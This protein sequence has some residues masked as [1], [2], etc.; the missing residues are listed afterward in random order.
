MNNTTEVSVK[1]CTHCQKTLPI[2]HFT[3]NTSVSSGYGGHCKKC[4]NSKNRRHHHTRKNDSDY[5]A[6]SLLSAARNRTDDVSLTKEWIAN[7]IAGGF[8]E[9]SGLPFDLDSGRP[10]RPFTP[11]LD[12]I[13]P[14]KGYT[15]ENTQVVCWIYNRAKGVHDHQAV[16]ILAKALVS[17]NDN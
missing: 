6:S 13:D 3:K 17:A 10:A 4:H 11:S 5:R 2:D 7:K 1:Q 8:C 12:R 15:P 16:L 14:T 9:A